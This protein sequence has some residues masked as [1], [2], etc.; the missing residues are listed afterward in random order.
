MVPGAAAPNGPAS[1]ILLGVYYGNDGATM[2]DVRALEAWQ[3]KGNAVVNLFT[4]WDPGPD[5][6]SL[7]EQRLPNIWANRNVPM[8]SWE[9]EFRGGTTDDIELRIARGEFDGYLN[10]WAVAMKVFLSGPDGAYGTG[11]DRRAYIRLAHEMNGNWYPWSPAKGG[12]TGADYVAMWRHVHDAFTVRGMDSTRL[13][14]VWSPN[15]ADYGGVTAEQVF[16]GDAYVDW[17]G[18]DGYNRALEEQSQGWRS[19]ATTFDRMLARMR[20]LSQRPVAIVESATT[21]FGAEGSDV[22]AKSK[23]L[24]DFFTYAISR[25]IR[26]VVYF[27]KDARTDWTIFGGPRGTSTFTHQGRT[28]KVYDAY[29]TAVARPEF[30]GTDPANPR[31]LDDR[32]FSGASIRR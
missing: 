17:L 3:S 8:I 15:R 21:S 27:N 16:P 7:F 28:F 22:D 13:Q 29:R 9:P 6:R 10:S 11:D 25:D 5:M 23:W 32:Q 30:I 4:G 1:G 26:M 14:W 19:V 18:L 24:S 20:K 2:D 12:G 31:L